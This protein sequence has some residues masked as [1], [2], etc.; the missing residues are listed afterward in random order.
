MNGPVVILKLMLMSADRVR[1]WK[2]TEIALECNITITSAYRYLQ[3]LTKHEMITR[4]SSGYIIG[5][6]VLDAGSKYQ[7]ALAKAS[8]IRNRGE[9]YGSK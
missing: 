3:K 2:V 5:S 4:T 1:P 6:L 7:L 8:N 9:I